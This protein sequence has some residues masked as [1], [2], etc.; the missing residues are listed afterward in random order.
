MTAALAGVGGMSPTLGTGEYIEDE[1]VVEEGGKG[2]GLN[3]VGEREG[4]GGERR[5]MEAV[6][7]QTDESAR[8][9]VQYH[10]SLESRRCSLENFRYIY[11]SMLY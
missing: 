3:V 1:G 8:E 4:G 11:L 2:G 9:K 5:E 10:S 6:E 7:G